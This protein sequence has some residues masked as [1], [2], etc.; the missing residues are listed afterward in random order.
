MT[1]RTQLQGGRIGSPSLSRSLLVEDWS[2][3]ERMLDMDR[4]LRLVRQRTFLVL[5]GALVLAGPWVGWWTLVP[6]VLAG[7]LFRAA[8]A[9][10]DR[11]SHPEYWM[12]GAWTAAELII[13]LSV[14]LTGNSAIFLLALLAVPV[15]TLSARFSTKGIWLGVGLAVILILAV[16][17]AADSQAVAEN[18]PLVVAPIAVVVAASMLSAALK[19]SDIEHRDKVAPTDRIRSPAEVI[20]LAILEK[21][22]LREMEEGFQVVV[23]QIRPLLPREIRLGCEHQLGGRDVER[24]GDL[25][26]SG[27]RWRLRCPLNVTEISAIYAASESRGFLAEPSFQ[28]QLAHRLAK[29]L[30]GGLCHAVRVSFR[31]LKRHGLK[32]PYSGSA[33][34][35]K[36]RAAESGSE[37][38]RSRRVWRRLRRAHSDRLCG[39]RSA[40]AFPRTGAGSLWASC[41]LLLHGL[42]F[43]KGNLNNP[44]PCSEQIQEGPMQY[45]KAGGRERGNEADGNTS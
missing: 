9:R 29:G 14:L 32:F 20:E 41:V 26:D 24:F 6:L 13:A 10:I 40:A 7:A 35:L 30:G 37:V 31:A 15:V 36:R 19:Q 25:P 44:E 16:A 33:L 5:A 34:L 28:P 18:P 11:A 3:R 43:S 42:K 45:R 23:D 21:V 27:Q 1:G 12:F 22:A 2:E 17:I 4:R 8:E 38:A 39:G